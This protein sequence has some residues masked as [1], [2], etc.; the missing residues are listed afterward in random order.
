M[1]IQALKK[2]EKKASPEKIT[3]AFLADLLFNDPSCTAGT[4]DVHGSTFQITLT[5]GTKNAHVGVQAIHNHVSQMQVPDNMIEIRYADQVAT[6]ITEA[7]SD[8]VIRMLRKST[9]EGFD[10]FRAQR[11]RLP[12]QS[13]RVFILPSCSHKEKTSA[14]FV[15]LEVDGATGTATYEA[16][17]FTQEEAMKSIKSSIKGEVHA[18]CSLL[19]E[20]PETARTCP[21][22][23]LARAFLLPE[24]EQFNKSLNRA[25]T[26][27]SIELHGLLAQVDTKSS[28]LFE[29]NVRFCLQCDVRKGC[30]A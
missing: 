21:R 13:A 3:Q 23:I 14:G 15:Q 19:R 11:L 5:C 2:G 20:Q 28:L 16:T 4:L 7:H 10:N 22:P 8:T 27:E 30:S 26:K 29:N 6:I 9:L 12:H 17:N 1:Y 25:A 24:L 18:I